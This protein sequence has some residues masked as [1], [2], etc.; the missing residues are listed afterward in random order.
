MSLMEG[1]TCSSQN[2]TYS[3]VSPT[4][5]ESLGSEVIELASLSYDN[6][7]SIEDKDLLDVGLFTNF[8]GDFDGR[9]M[10]AVVDGRG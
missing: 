7:A 3:S 5:L 9:N 8:G 10:G 6:R 1:L 4:D 2:L